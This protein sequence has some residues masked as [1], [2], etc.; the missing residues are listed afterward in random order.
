MLFVKTELNHGGAKEK[1]LSPELQKRIG[2][3]GLLTDTGPYD[4]RIDTRTNICTDVWTNPAL[5]VE[6]YIDNSEGSF[7]RVYFCGKQFVIVKAY[8]SE[9]IK[10]IA[11]DPRD[12]N[13]VSELDY[14]KDG[15]DELPISP[16]LKSE[17][18]TFIDKTPL[19]FGCLDI[20]HDDRENYTIVDL[21][22]TPSADSGDPDEQL[23]KFLKLG[24]TEAC[25]RKICG[26]TSSPMF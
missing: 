4:Y 11:A 23:S 14:L 17:V 18:A 24:I 19:E 16:R 22:L 7:Y 21:N 20:V 15:T 10:K 9:I 12:T 3:E 8:A 6:R 26:V 1:T 13:Y 2:L 5:V 25:Q